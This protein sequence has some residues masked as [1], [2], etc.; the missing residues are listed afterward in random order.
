MGAI[1]VSSRYEADVYIF[2][3]GTFKKSGIYISPG[4]AYQGPCFDLTNKMGTV[5]HEKREYRHAVVQYLPKDLNPV[6]NGE[7][8]E[9]GIICTGKVAFY[10]HC[11]FSRDKS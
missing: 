6:F 1:A 3:T 5:C 2:I 7:T 11:W 10:I 8:C 4:L 9:N